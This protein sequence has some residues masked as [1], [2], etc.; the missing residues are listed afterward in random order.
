MVTIS[1]VIALVDVALDSAVP[2]TCPA[3]DA[4]HD[5]RITVND[6]VAA[7]HVALT[8]CR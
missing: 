8:G 4:D 7:V 6:I 1:E 2:T 5:G 3:G